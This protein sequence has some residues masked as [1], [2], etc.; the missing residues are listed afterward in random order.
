MPATTLASGMRRLTN[1]GSAA[2]NKPANSKKAAEGHTARKFMVFEPFPGLNAMHRAKVS[3]RSMPGVNGG[4]RNRHLL[5][6]F[7]AEPFE[8]HNFAGVIG[9]QPDGVQPKIRKDLRAD[10]ALVL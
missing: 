10:A 2:G 9:E 4:R 1:C 3:K 8:S 5:N 7:D 6:D